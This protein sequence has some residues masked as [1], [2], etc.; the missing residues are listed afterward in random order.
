MEGD[1]KGFATQLRR[2]G[3]G[4]VLEVRSTRENRAWLAALSE[5][6]VRKVTRDGGHEC[7]AA[8]FCGVVETALA[9]RSAGVNIEF[10]RY[11]QLIVARP[12]SAAH[13]LEIPDKYRKRLYAVI[14][15]DL[16]A[17]QAVFTV[18]LKE[19]PTAPPATDDEPPSAWGKERGRS[20]P[21]PP[22]GFAAPSPVREISPNLMHGGAQR[23][24]TGSKKRAP[25][26]EGGDEAAALLREARAENA[27]LQRE[28]EELKSINRT[29]YHRA[30]EDAGLVEQFEKR[31][32]DL[33]KVAAALKKELAKLHRRYTAERDERM[34]LEAALQ[35]A[36]PP[37]RRSATRRQHDNADPLPRKRSSR[38]VSPAPSAERSPPR[39]VN[40]VDRL[41]RSASPRG[42]RAASSLSSERK[43]GG[44]GG[45]AGSREREM[46]LGRRHT[47]PGRGQAALLPGA[48]AG[49]RRQRGAA[50]RSSDRASDASSTPSRLS[51]G[52]SRGSVRSGS[53]ASSPGSRR[54]AAEARFD[55]IERIRRA[56]GG[57]AARSRPLAQPPAA[58][59]V[60][61]DT[62]RDSRSSFGS[63]TSQD[64]YP[65]L[66]SPHVSA[67]PP[68]SPRTWR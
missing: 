68:S 44:A 2:S 6:D 54:G 37:R 26:G 23:D 47:S 34:S 39:R 29:L 8:E 32:A 35:S 14:G 67:R 45:G 1:G 10:R 42:F 21:P 28:A 53:A 27:R 7:S 50:R 51:R 61:R 18:V 36:A 11:D 48:G 4:V 60:R 31:E 49:V 17:V 65:V 52:S 19:Q 9:R 38:G 66:R 41:A 3:G 58:R 33:Q 62:S 40:S 20:S 46:L 16:G 30:Q 24:P 15:Y 13:D 59:R 63:R 56:H 64:R 55:R 25:P 12:A 43:R 57:A 5:Q 22:H